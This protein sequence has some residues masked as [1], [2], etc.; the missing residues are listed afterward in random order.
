MA[1]EI[2][3][4]KIQHTNGTDAM[5]IDSSGRVNQ[6]AKPIM[7]CKSDNGATNLT[8]TGMWWR[9]SVNG[10]TTFLVNQGGI[11]HNGSDGKFTL[12]VTGI[13]RLE[14]HSMLLG[15]GGQVQ[16][17]WLKNGSST[18]LRFIGRGVDNSNWTPFDGTFVG[19]FSAGD[20]IQQEFTQ[21]GLTYDV[22][23][24]TYENFSIEMIG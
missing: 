15:N 11:T 16:W 23:G 21:V 17:R 2:G 3:V 22:H 5:T 8:S 1:S 6:P 18:L 9:D 4:Q 20:Y 14:Y 12:P 7:S 13:Y 19:S 10:G 24:Q